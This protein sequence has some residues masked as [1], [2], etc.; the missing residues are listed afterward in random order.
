MLPIDAVHSSEDG[1]IDVFKSSNYRGYV[2]NSTVIIY[3]KP[4]FKSKPIAQ[5]RYGQE[6]NLTFEKKY[7]FW[8]VRISDELSGWIYGTEVDVRNKDGAPTP[9]FDGEPLTHEEKYQWRVF[10]VPTIMTLF[11]G[12][13]YMQSV[14]FKNL[15]KTTRANSSFLAGFSI[16]FDVFNHW[17]IEFEG[18]RQ[19][20]SWNTGPKNTTM[21]KTLD[22][23][24]VNWVGSFR[25]ARALNPIKH[26]GML[27]GKSLVFLGLKF[28]HNWVEVSRSGHDRLSGIHK[29]NGWSV[30]PE[31]SV[32]SR[33]SK[34]AGFEWTLGY[35]HFLFNK[36]GTGTVSGDQKVS[37]SNFY[38]SIGFAMFFD[39]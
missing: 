30:G 3:S 28:A 31:L 19:W 21:E 2:R 37:P 15:A 6:L 23:E 26:G 17:R 9:E 32:M 12:F 25:I 24:M 39:D 35:S 7:G 34:E 1:K 16:D 33:W 13:T 5:A 11:G 8:E 22:T 20:R 36:M 10:P 18:Q 29:A 38:T 4:S 27:E 14:G